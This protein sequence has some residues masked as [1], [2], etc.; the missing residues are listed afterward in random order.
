M[1]ARLASLTRPR[2]VE[3]FPVVLD[4]RRIYVLPTRFGLFIA[5]MLGSML[6][7][8]LNYNNN[9]ALL[10]GFLLAATAQLSL[11][12]THLVLSGIRLRDARAAPVHAGDDLI[13]ELRF[14]ALRARARPGLVLTSGA[15][16]TVFSL[17]NADGVQVELLLPTTK[18]G[19]LQPGRLTVSTTQPLGLAR[20][21]SYF[22]PDLHLLVYPALEVH[23]P[24]L[25]TQSASGT[26]ARVR[27]QGEEPH[28]LRDYRVGDPPRQV[29]W[30]ASARTG[31]LLVREYEARSD[32]ELWLDW[33]TLTNLAVEMRISRLARWV[34]EA[35]RINA[36]YT[37]I[38]PGLRLGPA[39]GHAHRHACLQALALLPD[40]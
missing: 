18:R 16:R 1:R 31:K 15:A 32:R 22:W 27:A 8:A 5:A 20:A 30:K 38:V 4:R 19:W 2:R 37:L 28:H 40:G 26:S 13:L 11:H 39:Q 7:G 35:D 12:A 25:P 24:Q 29:A 34:V 9:P 23:A 3:A 33:N 17:S 10:L 14:D 36:R 21:W 6:L